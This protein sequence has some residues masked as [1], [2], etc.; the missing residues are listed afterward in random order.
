MDPGSTAEKYSMD[1]DLFF[2]HYKYSQCKVA[3]AGQ[4]GI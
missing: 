4:A 3:F 1:I 2:K